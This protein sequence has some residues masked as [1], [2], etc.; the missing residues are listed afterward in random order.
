MAIQ[1]TQNNNNEPFVLDDNAELLDD[2]TLAVNQIALTKGMVLSEV[3][4]TAGGKVVGQIVPTNTSGTDGTN[5]PKFL[6]VDAVAVNT[7]ATQTIAAYTMGIF[8]ENQVNFSA[9]SMALTTMV[10]MATGRVESMK[11]ALRDV[12]IRLAPG[13]SATG[14]ENS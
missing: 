8:D 6:S 14:Y 10:T 3:A 2:L 1:A 7:S 9:T 4:S 13:L 11:N 5:I 12:G